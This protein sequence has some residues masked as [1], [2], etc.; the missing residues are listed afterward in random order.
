MGSP[1]TCAKDQLVLIVKQPISSWR[2]NAFAL[3]TIPYRTH[4]MIAQLV[5]LSRSL[6]RPLNQN[7]SVTSV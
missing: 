7:G 1:L 4:Y 5:Q 2:N 6:F 3:K